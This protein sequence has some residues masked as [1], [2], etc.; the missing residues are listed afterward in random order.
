[1][2]RW[3][4]WIIVSIVAVCLVDGCGLTFCDAWFWIGAVTV[5]TGLLLVESGEE[6]DNKEIKEPDALQVENIKQGD[7]VFWQPSLQVFKKATRN[8]DNRF[9][10]RRVMQLQSSMPK[11]VKV[12]FLHPGDKLK[13]MKVNDAKQS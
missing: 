6:N 9:V 11:G 2:K 13:I 3:A 4:G 12:L 5:V 10:Q 1:M 8:S 7:T